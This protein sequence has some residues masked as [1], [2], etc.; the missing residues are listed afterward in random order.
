VAW[1]SLIE[2][3]EWAA[4]D[5]DPAEDPGDS[6]QPGTTERRPHGTAK[7]CAASLRGSSARP[8]GAALLGLAEY[9][10]GDDDR[11]PGTTD[12]ELPDLP[13]S[14]HPGRLRT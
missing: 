5:E 14:L 2:P 10:A 1:L 11:F 6:P 3:E 9:A 13:P 4:P 7:P 8:S 12:D